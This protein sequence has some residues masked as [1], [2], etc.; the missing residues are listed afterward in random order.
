MDEHSDD[1]EVDKK[2]YHGR[3][4]QPRQAEVLLWHRGRRPLETFFIVGVL[5]F[6]T[7]D[8]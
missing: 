4:A 6:G 5:S 3:A 8:R 1:E 2:Q 7:E